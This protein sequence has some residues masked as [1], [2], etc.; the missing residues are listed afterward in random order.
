MATIARQITKGEMMA[1]D[2]N[3]V[4]KMRFNRLSAGQRR[5]INEEFARENDG[6]T[7]EEAEAYNRL[8][9]YEAR[10]QALR[11]AAGGFVRGAKAITGQAAEGAVK[12]RKSVADIV[13]ERSAA[14]QTDQALSGAAP[15]PVS[16]PETTVPAQATPTPVTPAP[17]R[18]QPAAPVA[19]KTTYDFPNKAFKDEEYAAAEKQMLADLGDMTVNSWKVSDPQT[20][21]N[22]LHAYTAKS[23]GLKYSETPPAPYKF[24]V[25]DDIVEA[26]DDEASTV[27]KKPM[28]DE[29][30]PAPLFLS[31]KAKKGS[32]M[33]VRSFQ[34][35]DDLLA[36]IKEV[37]QESFQDLRKSSQLK[38]I[39]DMVIGATQGDFRFSKGREVDLSKP[40]DV[41]EF[42][43]MAKTAQKRLE[44][45]RK[46]HKDVPPITLYHGSKSQKGA[47]QVRGTGFADPRRI[48]RTEPGQLE[49]NVSIPSFTRDLNLPFQSGA[50]GGR[51]PERFVALEMPYAD[52]VFSRVNMPQVAYDQK[53]LNVIARAISGDPKQVRPLGLPRAGMYETEDSIVDA[54]KLTRSS[55]RLTLPDDDITARMGRFED[56]Q[57]KRSETRSKVTNAV[58]AWNTEGPKVKTANEI[59]G[60]IRDYTKSLYRNAEIT[61]TKAGIGQK[62]EVNFT[63]MPILASTMSDAAKVLREAGSTE[64]AALLEKIANAKRGFNQLNESEAGDAQKI[65]QELMKTIP[66]LNK[67]GLVARKK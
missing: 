39:D 1:K 54:E 57:Q 41:A 59:Y 3:R 37:R 65:R 61:S 42:A 27:F 12:G 10:L 48:E 51:N 33:N 16:M 66:K 18:R 17:V 28:P 2:L 67:G 15:Q 60:A 9:E 46:K 47:E 22:T 56:I 43:D 23:K 4:Y 40:K 25:A 29:E 44:T 32:L 35:R 55:G 11:F 38:G 7:L 24:E 5:I 20:F 53:N 26:A 14:Q 58:E 62:F 30:E 19:A 13:R 64:R 50:F 49:L 36:Q 21:A 34:D 45:L 31:D 52:Y 8:D 63:N 6:V